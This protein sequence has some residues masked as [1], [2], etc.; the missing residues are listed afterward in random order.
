MASADAPANTATAL[1]GL[2]QLEVAGADARQGF[3][4]RA[5]NAAWPKLLAIAIVL[6]IWELLYL[7]GWKKLIFPGP[8]S[9]LST[10]ADATHTAE[11]W[12]AVGITA[13][14]AVEGFA[15]A[16]VIGGVIGALVARIKLL[17]AA[18]GSMISAL[19]TMPSI[20]WFPFGIILFGEVR[21]TILFVIVLDAAPSVA[22]GLISGIDYTPPLLI[23]AGQVMGLRRVQLYWRL[24]LPAALPV[25]VTGL[26]QSWAFAWRSLLAGEI[27]IPISG[28]PSLGVLLSTYQDQTDEASVI[29]IMIVI[30]I[31]GVAVDA[32]F[33]TIDRRIRSGRGLTPAAG[34][35]SY[36]R[37]G[38]I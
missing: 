29:S 34:N 30:L 35:G 38:R 19:Q 14:T 26:R 12:H 25:F 1:A 5:W 6:A 16:L 17:R 32:I 9:T 27:L 33:G 4:V 2:D 31:L 3:A 36:F 13:L 22:N 8:A 18:V 11:L 24:I 20:A 15:M 23:K 28:I 37:P 7:S 21:A 10:L